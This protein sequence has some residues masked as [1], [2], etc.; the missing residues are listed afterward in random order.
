[1][2]VI[3][4]IHEWCWWPC[5]TWARQKSKCCLRWWTETNDHRCVAETATVVNR[6]E[7]HSMMSSYD[8]RSALSNTIFS[9]QEYV[10][11]LTLCR[12]FVVVV[13]FVQCWC[14]KRTQTVV[15]RY[16]LW[17]LSFARWHHMIKEMLRMKLAWL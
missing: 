4:I 16:L 15:I 17:L 2:T 10:K 9:W 7:R 12:C 13:V 14:N 8:V 5:C 3:I 11:L 6:Q 1:M